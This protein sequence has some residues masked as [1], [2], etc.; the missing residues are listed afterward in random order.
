MS[1]PARNIPPSQESHP[2]SLNWLGTTALAIGGSNQS[3][4]LI[5]IL[6]AGQDRLVGHGT[7]G[8]ALLAV[9]LLLSLFAA[10]GWLELVLMWPNRVGGIAA[11]C[12]EAFR[13]YSPVLAN[14]TGVCYWW[15]WI[16]TCGLTA[17]LAAQ[18][19]H[20][21]GYARMPVPVLAALIVTTFTAINLLGIRATAWLATPIALIAAVLAFLSAIIPVAEGHVN[22]HQSLYFHLTLPFPGVFGRIT[23][24]M[25]GLYLV[26]F[27]APAFEA[28]TCHVGETKNPNRNV[29]RAMV[30]SAAVAVLYFAILPMVWLGS[31]GPAALTATNLASKLGPTFAPLLGSGVRA[32]A[33]FMI[34]NMFLG[35]AQP[36]AG[37]SR[38]IAQLADDGLLPRCFAI[39]SRQFDV[40]WVATL[41]T[42]AVA[43]MFLLG[44]D[45]L[46][47][48]AAANLTYL[49]G[50]GLPSVAVWLLRRNSPKMVRPYRAPTPMIYLG[51]GSAIVWLI[52]SLLGFQQYGL[53][54]VLFGIVLAYSG[55][56][57][58]AARRISDAVTYEHKHIKFGSL[59]TKLTGAMLLVLALDG[60]GY[61]L[62]V[63]NVSPSLF[64]LRAVLEDI[65]VA[66]ALLTISVGLVLP[67]I[68][69]HTTSELAAAAYDLANGTLAEFS[70]AMEELGK[71]NLNT[72]YAHVDAQPVQVRSNDEIGALAK[73]F[74]V[75]VS[76]VAR[77]QKGLIGAR[78]G[79]QRT[80]D[81]LLES[82]AN[83]EA[84]VASR[85]EALHEAYAD[86][87][88]SEER[89]RS[90][91]QNA[92]DVITVLDQYGV[93]TYMS[94][95]EERILGYTPE[96]LKNEI[97]TSLVHSD[98]L[99]PLRRIAAVLRKRPDRSPIVEVRL[100][101]K[102]G[103]WRTIE[104]ICRNYLSDPAISGIVV[105]CRDIT[106]RHAVDED[107][108]KL[109]EAT[110]ARA[111]RE[112]IVNQI[113]LN[114][115]AS[116]DPDLIELSAVSALGKAL[117][118]DRCYFAYY[119]SG[120]D[121][122]VIARDW[123]RS[124]IP[125][126]AGE[127]VLSSF[128]ATTEQ[129]NAGGRTLV[130]SD[131]RSSGMPEHTCAQLEAMGL[132]SGIRVPIVRNGQVLTVLTVA[133]AAEPR[134]WTADEVLLV[135]TIASQTRSAIEA[136]LVHQREHDIA[137]TL[138]RALLPPIPREVP[139]LDVES[140]YKAALDESAIGGDFYDVFAVQENVYALVVGDVSG[141]GLA[142][143]AQ[144]STVRQMLRCVL[145]LGLS[146]AEAATQLNQLLIEHSLLSGFV[147]LSL[148]L[149]NTKTNRMT[150]VS[151]GH[152]PGLL[153]R[154]ATSSIEQ[155][156]PT[157]MPLGIRSAERYTDQ[158]VGLIEGDT[159]LMYT[160][161]LSEAISDSRELLGVHGLSQILAKSGS[162]P[163][164][165]D[166]VDHVV[167][168][169][170]AYAGVKLR[171]DGCILSFVVSPCATDNADD[172][173]PKVDR[174]VGFPND[175]LVDAQPSETTESAYRDHKY[176]RLVESSPDM[177]A[178]VADGY[179]TSVNSAGVHLLNANTAAEIIGKSI[180][181]FVPDQAKTLFLGRLRRLTQGH[182]IEQTEQQWLS[183]TGEPMYIELT[184]TP[185]GHGL[186]ES[187]FI[188]R[189]ITSRKYIEEENARLVCEVQLAA[190]KQHSFLRDVLA[191]VSEGHLRLAENEDE[192][193]MP[194]AQYGDHI[195]LTHDDIREIRYLTQRG[196]EQLGL[197]VERTQDLIIAVGEASMNAVAHGG[198]GVGRVHVSDEGKIQVWI[199]DSGKGIAQ[200]HLPQALLERGFTTANSLGYGFWMIL[201][202]ID[203]VWLLTSAEGTTV[204]LEQNRTKP[205]GQWPAALADRGGR[206]V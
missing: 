156:L 7:A 184:A 171:D 109:M 147:T 174:S 14:L 165:R 189:D 41:T 77:A 154:R 118:A 26:G 119:D 149:V 18:A 196:A 155:L 92:S 103:S 166:V 135:E 195:P 120:Q 25:A 148:A 19:I 36:L 34:C 177:V 113:G 11:T 131:V 2:R 61:Y 101:H 170:D 3:L 72:P 40:P 181:D 192:L 98:D 90:L 161:G 153:R 182:P 52:S 137:D 50:I 201:Q 175:L 42:A 81:A 162:S 31:I 86:L 132:R 197:D 143:A 13:P 8:V 112:T 105:N 88:A 56:A 67:G 178:T 168:A 94:P 16:P 187:Q 15:G 69:A 159:L 129:I 1:V 70:S 127:L 21:L 60:A 49:I 116:T 46:W 110:S 51:L 158:F 24:L 138:Q 134:T 48:I 125:S 202:S 124:G 173:R 84:R 183:V 130:L 190:S 54:T 200:E 65:F 58:Y 68:V 123:H 93:I 35:T 29:P 12:A 99:A 45:P 57:L 108:R 198:G 53:Q 146:A 133:M 121:A 163:T 38:T 140:W 188:I 115:R 20:Q 9:G 126:I 79:L 203:Q 100:R 55:S 205:E 136:A 59:H 107:R 62:A 85:T 164:A 39:R 5:G 63:S 204:V 91:V 71:G 176:S 186:Q 151:C 142:A 145:Y 139:G 4:F 193:P 152:E 194:L 179:F 122:V 97:F 73:T 89:F 6:I 47:L 44:N 83:L 144:V 160:D 78:A 75:V 87:R 32:A 191:S 102:D 199:T 117:R 150:Y 37:A 106:E 80:R 95:S 141:K 82:N 22:W 33:A 128:G 96:R 185:I 180:L 30:A 111:D 167:N 114:S 206:S 17:L 169:I 28:A 23:G 43:I 76:E 64:A 27:A 172:P 10:P 157:G 104:A 66:V 74:N